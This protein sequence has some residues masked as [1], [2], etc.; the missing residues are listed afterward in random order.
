VILGYLV[1]RITFKLFVCQLVVAYFYTTSSTKLE[2]SRYFS[3]EIYC[4]WV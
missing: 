2:L 4:Y 1:T 3:E